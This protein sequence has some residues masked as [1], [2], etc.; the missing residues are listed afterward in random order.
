MKKNFTLKHSI[1]LTL[2]AAAMTAQGANMIPDS[3]FEYGDSPAF[4]RMRDRDYLAG[5]SWK[6]DDSTALDGRRSL[7]GE[8]GRQLR[9]A[10]EANEPLPTAERPWTFSIYLKSTRSNTTVTLN[11]SAY[12]RLAQLK[13][14]KHFKVGTDWTRCELTVKKFKFSRRLGVNQGP[15]NFAVLI[16]KGVTVWADAAQWEAGGQATRYAASKVDQPVLQTELTRGGTPPPIPTPATV[17]AEKS[18][19]VGLTVRNENSKIASNVPLSTGIIVPRGEFGANTGYTLFDASGREIPCQT[20]PIALHLADRSVLSLKLD[21]EADLQP[22]DNRFRLRYNTHN[23]TTTTKAPLSATL[24]VGDLLFHPS[25]KPDQLWG[26]FTNRS[27][28]LVI[29]PGTLGATGIDGCAYRGL[30]QKI[31]TETDGPLHA[32]IVMSGDLVSEK[33]PKKALLSYEARLHLWKHMP[34]VAV[35]LT[36]TN[37]HPKR[38]VALRDL[39][40]KAPLPE[41]SAKNT[42]LLQVFDLST[43]KFRLGTAGKDRSFRFSDD[44]CATMAVRNHGKGVDY[45]LQTRDGWRKHPTEVAILNREAQAFF[46]P[47]QPV[48]PLLFSPGMAVTRISTLSAYPRKDMPKRG[49]QT[50]H[51]EDPPIVVVDPEWSLRA[52]IPLQLN[53]IGKVPLLD[54]YLKNY[55][56]EGMFCPSGIEK[57]QLHGL[58]NYGDHTGDGGWANLESYSDY[59]TL[60]R[61]LRSGSPETLRLGLAAAEHYRDMDV[62]HIKNLTIMHSCNHVIGNN[63]FGHAWIQGILL[64]YLMTGDQRSREVVHQIGNAFLAI[65]IQSEDIR[66]NRE[67]GYYLLTMADISLALGDKRYINRFRIQLKAAEKL[68]AAPPKPAD[69]ATQRRSMQR[70]T[71][72]RENSLFYWVNSGIAPFAC[73]YGLA[74]LLKMYE[75]TGNKSLLPHIRNEIAI[76]LDIESL[77]RVHL[78]ELYPN[79]PAEKTLPLIASDYVGGR[80]SYF[81]PVMTAC[82]RVTGEKKYRDLAI[83]VAYARILE[84]KSD[85]ADILMSA[86]FLD[87]PAGFDDEKM[88]KEVKAIYFDGAAKELLNGDFSQTRSYAEMMTPKRPDGITPRWARNI[89]Y[90]RYWRLNAGKQFT[91]TEFMRYRPLLY[92]LGNNTLTLRFNRKRWFTRRTINFDSA[93]IKFL[94]GIWKFKGKVKTD[95]NTGNPL[96]RFFF[97]DFRHPQGILTLAAKPGAKPYL[98]SATPALPKLLSYS[99]SKPDQDGFV[100]VK[101]EFDVT[102]PEVGFIYFSGFLLP[103]KARGEIKIRELEFKPQK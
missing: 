78:E 70:T 20:A 61:S 72:H 21:F 54:R 91:A 68:L 41:S 23:P 48:Q 51:L 1:L 36:V 97:S 43:K 83:K 102:V 31:R 90:P 86:P 93:R 55:E 95:K 81:Y 87:L 82:S 103:G 46:W 32:V 94:P 39:F 34:G 75:I 49:A 53:R 59:S 18:G 3:S 47:G 10:C 26:S 100:T 63:H 71:R 25:R 50:A 28:K 17:A 58:F 88:I 30:N 5:Y 37:R 24:Q 92:T 96:F 57:F 9:F 6:S 76:S 52:G 38:T 19:E 42:A 7:R 84:G 44:K 14:R 4:N 64:H 45:Q 79:L 73:W 2:F 60:L 77:Y 15:V 85:V 89:P 22:G 65:P 98:Q 33:N 62:N 35:Q 16:P 13:V 66:E 99:V 56:E 69:R 74:G 11:V 12:R 101:A 29:G 40:W 27:G 80:G 8:N 67:L